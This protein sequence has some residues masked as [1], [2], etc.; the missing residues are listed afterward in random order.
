MASVLRAGKSSGRVEGLMRGL[1]PSPQNEQAF[2]EVIQNA[3]FT[4]HEFRIRVKMETFNVR[5]LGGGCCHIGGAGL[6][7]TDSYCSSDLLGKRT[8]THTHHSLEHQEHL[9]HSGTFPRWGPILPG[10]AL[11][12][13]ARA[14]LGQQKLPC[15]VSWGLLGWAG[16]A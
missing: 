11:L 3:N 13:Q 12:L 14:G 7:E 4:S 8:Q 5:G 9:G 15:R 10:G 2:D 16:I 6:E 1:F